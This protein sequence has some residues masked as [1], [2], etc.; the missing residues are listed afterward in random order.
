MVNPTQMPLR[1]GGWMRLEDETV[2]ITREGDTVKVPKDAITKIDLEVVKWGLAA[3]SAVTLLFG[4]YFAVVEH[5]FGGLAIATI[6]AWSL[7]RTYRQRNT[8]VIWV[9]GRTK[10]IAVYPENPKACHAAVAKLVRP[11]ETPVTAEATSGRA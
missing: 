3:M 9:D 5:P 4:A 6:G 11:E 10:P 1:H 7:H 2:R 8:L